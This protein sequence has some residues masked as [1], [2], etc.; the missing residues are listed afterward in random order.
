MTAASTPENQ[1]YGYVMESCRFES[2]CPESSAYLGRP[3]RDFAK[4]VLINCYMDRHICK[5]GWHD[6]NKAAA[7]ETAFYAEYGSFGP[8]AAMEMRPD[9]IHRLEKEDLRHYTKDA[10]LKGSD[11]W[12]PK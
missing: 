9:W 11:G 5:A 12:M 2:N 1:E 6:W 4:T 10:V 7:H 3:W 8:G